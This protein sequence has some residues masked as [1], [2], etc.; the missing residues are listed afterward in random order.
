MST[1]GIFVLTM[2]NKNLQN[3]LIKIRCGWMLVGRLAEQ[4]EPVLG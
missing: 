2:R 3:D 4:M 1:A